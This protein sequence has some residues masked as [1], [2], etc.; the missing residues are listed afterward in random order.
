MPTGH[1]HGPHPNRVGA[2]LLLNNKGPPPEPVGAV[3]RV[4]PPS[5]PS[6]PSTST[7]LHRST[8]YVHRGVGPHLDT[9]RYRV[10]NPHHTST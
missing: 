7:L 1:T 9:Y 3:L 2:V 8:A 10:E 4:R 6:T 5:T